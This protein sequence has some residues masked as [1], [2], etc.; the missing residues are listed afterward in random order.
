[1]GRTSYTTVK[2]HSFDATGASLIARNL[3]LAARD[4]NSSDHIVRKMVADIE[5][6]CKSE[7]EYDFNLHALANG[8]D[9]E[10]TGDS[11]VFGDRA[12][13]TLQSSFEVLLASDL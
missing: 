12:L 7:L 2:R 10:I 3:F 5:N 1:M 13:D 4:P 9:D 11:A 8:L 6:T